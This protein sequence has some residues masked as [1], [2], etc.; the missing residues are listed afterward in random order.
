MV[1]FEVLMRGLVGQDRVQLLVL[2]LF[3]HRHAA[4]TASS[5]ISSIP[6]R[7]PRY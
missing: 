2:S 1:Q 7:A 6:Y 5:R 4:W 3:D